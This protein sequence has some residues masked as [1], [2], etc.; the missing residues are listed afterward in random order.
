M[1]LDLD[2]LVREVRAARGRVPARRS[3]LV[4]LTG[5]DGCGKGFVASRLGSALEAEGLRAG[6][7]GIDG[8][9]NLP[10]ARFSARRPAEHFYR[11]AIRFEELFS[12]LVFP[13]RERRSIRLEADLAEETA[14][15]YRRHVWE[16][17]DLDLILLEGIYLLKRA[18]QGLYDLS[19]WIDCTRATALE[20]ARA[21]AQEGLSPAETERVYRTV[22]FP[23][24]AIHMKR[25]RPRRAASRILANDA[26]LSA[27]QGRGS[28]HTLR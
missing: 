12:Q 4:A 5:I 13:L 8:W 6:V 3:G 28:T 18:F 15:D 10:R 7:I 23:A 24:Q 14:T 20:R 16:Y 22:Y 21:R 27:A 26:Q 9:L 1:P 19:I 25:D 17:A 11:H 2:P